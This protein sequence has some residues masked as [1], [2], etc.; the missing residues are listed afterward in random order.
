MAEERLQKMLRLIES[1]GSISAK[2][3]EKQLYVSAATVRRDLSVLAGRGL[4]VRG[5][6]KAMA[7]TRIAQSARHDSGHVPFA[8]IG[9]AAAR[10]IKPHS[11]VFIG[12]G[13]I[14]LSL[15]QAASW[16][17][18]LTVVTDSLSIAEVLCGHAKRLYCTGGCPLEQD[19]LVGGAAADIAGLFRYNNAFFCCDSLFDGSLCYN[20]LDRMPIL[21]AAARQAERKVLLFSGKQLD[22]EPGSPLLRLNDMD[23]IVTDIPGHFGSPAHCMIIG[24]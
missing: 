17:E 12:S 22:T 20:G 9:A 8:P 2:E 14:G 13:D 16:I 15:A 19:A 11:T 21:H 7:V 4:I 6:G 1:S 24:A 23:C 3:L 18:D 10:L 5:H